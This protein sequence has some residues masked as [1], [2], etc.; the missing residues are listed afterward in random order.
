M[1]KYKKLAEALTSALFNG[2]KANAP[3][4]YD[5][6]N[7]QEVGLDQFIADCIVE[8]DYDLRFA[9]IS[10]GF[11]IDIKGSNPFGNTLIHNTF[12]Q[13]LRSPFISDIEVKEYKFVFDMLNAV[14]PHFIKFEDK[15]Y[16][17][18]LEEELMSDWSTSSRVADVQ[19]KYEMGNRLGIY[20]I[21]IISPEGKEIEFSTGIQR[22]VIL[23]MSLSMLI[24]NNS[25]FNV[26]KELAVLIN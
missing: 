19:I 3:K 16:L 15:Q 14:L 20:S 11:R 21:T 17:Q 9:V 26:L 25:L 4:I 18:M 12:D 24:D 23:I 7:K 6:S 22:F 5:L 1:S 13:D 2:I 8:R 10:D